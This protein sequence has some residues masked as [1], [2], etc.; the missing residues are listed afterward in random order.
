MTIQND[1]GA[2]NYTHT[3]IDID[4]VHVHIPP[5]PPPPPGPPRYFKVNDYG[6]GGVMVLPLAI[7]TMGFVFLVIMLKLAGIL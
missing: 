4:G 2:K 7:A 1:Y 5:E 3:D 6:T